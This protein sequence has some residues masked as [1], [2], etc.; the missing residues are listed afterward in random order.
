VDWLPVFKALL[1]AESEG[2]V[3]R[4]LA[5]FDLD[6]LSHW[7]PLGGIENNFS[8]AGNQHA[9]ATGALVEKIIN[10]ID[11]KLM[12]GCFAAGLD[13]EGGHAPSSM[14]EAVERFLG[15]KHGRLGDLSS[16]Q[17]TALAEESIHLVA[18]GPK[19]EPCYLIID[20][21]EGQTPRSFPDTFLSLS[22]SNKMRIP[23]VQGRFNSGGT[24]VLPFCG[25]ENYQL[26][27]SRRHP[28]A[29]AAR[30]D[31]SATFWGFTLIRRVEPLEGDSRRNSMYMYLA[32]TNVIPAFD[33]PTVSVLPGT[34]QPN[35]PPKAYTRPLQYGT[36]VKLYNYR[37]RARS[38]ATTDA[39]FE[40]EKYLHSP[41][42]PF[43]ITETRAYNAN[44]FSTTVSGI[45]ATIE[46]QSST[47]RVEPGFPATAT[48][49]LPAVGQLRYRVAVFRPDVDSRRVP[50]GVFFSLNGQVHGSL[51]PD[52]VSRKLEFEYLR[53][54]LLV[55]VDCSQMHTRVRE[56]FFMASR[57][58]LRQNDIYDEIVAVLQQDLKAHPGLRELNAA[59]RAKAVE[60]ALGDAEDVAQTFDELLRMDPTLR[61]LFEIGSRLP[62]TVGPTQPQPFKGRRFP[63][64]FRP[65]GNPKGAITKQCP[66]NRTC[67]VEF[68]TDA[69]N[70]Y[71]DRTNSPGEMVINPAANLERGH[72]W[73]GVYSAQF[74]PVPP[75]KPND[76]QTVIVA[77]TDPDRASRGLPP[78]QSRLLIM[79]GSE[80]TSTSRPGGRKKNGRGPGGKGHSG[81]GLSMPNVIEVRKE[82]WN[83]YQPSLN[84]YDALRIMRGGDGNYDYHVNLDNT[85]LLNELR[86]TKEGD[87][88]VTVYWFKWG[89]VLCALGMLQHAK[90][91]VSGGQN[92]RADDEPSQLTTDAVEAI[93]EIIGGLGS[94]IVPTIRNLYRGP[95]A[96]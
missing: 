61:S 37:W 41:C 82:Q 21:G 17:Q 9:D 64:Y 85:Y 14:L 58:R 25:R 45:W 31:S 30:D 10:S 66:I 65:S 96:S 4:I 35:R 42:L 24:G 23:F 27:A 60:R 46:G 86:G 62:T 51:P 94:I 83:D 78:F 54:H 89:L 26:I 76:R 39:R 5:Q 69:A 40:L 43:R 32:P 55:S 49:N 20:T 44:Y 59:R 81:A 18:V 56:D 13:P 92:V 74:K 48:L 16:K 53:G 63:T 15:V 1:R 77:V 88:S 73:N 11:A 7:Q 95:A 75:C 93:N 70:D 8:T 12:A 6:D 91:L 36:I 38:T 22:K 3:T 68:E 19:E 90:R 50:H 34:S 47:E 79:V 80:D 67:R 28:E 71:F 2:Q 33:A 84:G 87:K 57:D 29:P 72:L 52:F